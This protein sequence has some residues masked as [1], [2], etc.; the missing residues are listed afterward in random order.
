MKLGWEV[1]VVT[2]QDY[3]SEDEVRSFNEAQSFTVL[4]LTP[5]TFAPFEALYRLRVLSRWARTWKPDIL[6]AS[7]D[8]AVFLTA[9]WARYRKIPW[10]AVGHGT[11][12]SLPKR[13]ERALVR[14]SF[15]R[16]TAVACVSRYTQERM[17]ATGVR[18][19]DS[20]VIQNG[21]DANV[22]T[23]LPESEVTRVRESL[24]VA[25]ARVLLTVGSVTERKGQDT[26]IRSLP[27]ILNRVTDVH[28]LVAG[29]PVRA[30]ELTQLAHHLNVSDHV[31]FLGQ[32]NSRR[33]VQ[34]LNCCDVFVMTSKH[35]ADG[36]FEGYGIA[37]IEAALCGK[38][39]VVS[40]NSGLAETISDGI[41]GLGVP[42][43]D[44]VAT[45]RAILTLLEDEDGRRKMGE[46]ARQNALAE[47]TWEHKAREYDTLLHR[48]L[49]CSRVSPP[50]RFSKVA[51]SAQS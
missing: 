50:E 29:M 14:R 33:L 18:P 37:V 31:H 39:A 26:V 11:E 1:A 5:Y 22:F 51:E 9:A 4:R 12:F 15:S 40:D 28:Y 47:C 32:V 6:M 24:G 17:R 23:V 10:V 35:T 25:G 36:D 45:A 27:H 34:L 16:A 46:T 44:E 48:V 41:T 7:G 20:A 42:E 49:K 43:G 8:R 2:S 3:A 30:G 21:A 13:W 19:N 38:P